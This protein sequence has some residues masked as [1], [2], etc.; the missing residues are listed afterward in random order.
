[1]TDIDKNGLK[2]D[3]RASFIPYLWLLVN[4]RCTFLSKIL[5]YGLILFG[6]I[7]YPQD[8]SVCYGRCIRNGN[9]DEALDL[10]AFVL[11]LS[12]VHPE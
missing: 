5:L 8:E 2:F 4:T 6:E 1:M 7:C 10:E 3:L 11:R 9:Y 12:K